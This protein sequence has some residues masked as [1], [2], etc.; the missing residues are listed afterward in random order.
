MEAKLTK[1]LIVK[2]NYNINLCNILIIIIYWIFKKILHN[3]YDNNYI[4]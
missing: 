3:L 4:L 1:K 2:L